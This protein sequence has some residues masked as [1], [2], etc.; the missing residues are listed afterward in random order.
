MKHSFV[1]LLSITKTQT[2]AE[3]PEATEGDTRAEDH[4]T[5]Q[6]LPVHVA[7]AKVSYYFDTDICFYLFIY[8]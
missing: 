5:V 4:G 2:S 3:Q 7:E 1:T 6:E 8:V